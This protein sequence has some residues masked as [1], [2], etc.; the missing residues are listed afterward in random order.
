MIES[1]IRPRRRT[2]AHVAGLRQVRRDVIRIGR[3]VVVRQVARN[4]G[5]RGDVVVVVDVAV[6]AQPRRHRVHPGQSE[7]RGR[8]VELAIG[9]QGR[10][11]AVLAG[12][13]E[14]GC[15]VRHR[16]GRIVVIGLVAGNAG[17]HRDAVVV[18][19]VAINARARR[20]HVIAGQREA[21]GVVIEGRIQPGRRGMAVLAGLREI[22]R[23]VVRIV[24]VLEVRQ[25]AGHA[26]GA[27]QGVV[28]V[29]VAVGAEPRRHGMQA[30]QSKTGRG[31]V[32][33]AIGPQVRVVALL[34]GGRES[35]CCVGHWGIR[36][37]V[38]G[39]VARNAGRIRNVVIVVDV[40]IRALPRRHHVIAGQRERGLRVIKGRRLPGAG[41]VASIARLGESSRD[42]I[43]IGRVLEVL[44]MARNAGRAGQIV[45]P[46]DVAVR[47]LPRRHR[48]H[49][50]QREVH[51]AVIKGRR[52]PSARGMALRA[53]GAGSSPPRG[54]DW[55][56]PGNPP[57]DSRRRRCWSDC[58]CC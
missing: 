22:R 37:V 8:V 35:R 49:A 48:V 36:I 6:G 1:R 4:A 23:D 50:G 58:S 39:L 17:R 14:S 55:S 12:G 32:E 3:V 43:R 38:I 16:S 21:S 11:V 9:P 15:R 54:W 51:R 29:D 18:V 46:I 42:V 53:V 10:V 33:H 26:R 24:G 5:R 41:R 31:V 19:D 30:G 47:T 45:V 56:C 20:H 7:T 27:A 28:V 52:R 2:V 57:C 13:R 25:V 44:E 40:A 34:A